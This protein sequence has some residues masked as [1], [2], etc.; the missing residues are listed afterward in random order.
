MGS[1]TINKVLPP[2]AIAGLLALACDFWSANPLPVGSPIDTPV[3]TLVDCDEAEQIAVWFSGEL[4]APWRLRERVR[5]NLHAIRTG[6]QDSVLAVAIQ[7]VPPWRISRVSAGVTGQT[8]AAIRDD[9]YDAWD[10]LNE[11]YGFDSVRYHFC[12]SVCWLALYF[13]GCQNPVLLAEAYDTLPGFEYSYASTWFG[14]RPL[15]L[16]HETGSQMTYFFRDAWGDCPAGCIHSTFDIFT[17]I[18][19]NIVYVGH[20]GDGQRLPEPWADWLAEAF[21]RYWS[22]D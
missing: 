8:W 6:W 21:D 13:E 18:D 14:D 4:T 9:L 5:D 22:Q 10:S 1:S 17:T 7:F 12:Y 3:D 19:N 11:N 15:L 20:F 2:L 16:L